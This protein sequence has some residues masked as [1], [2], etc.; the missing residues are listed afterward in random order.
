MAQLANQHYNIVRY[1]GTIIY[2][3]YIM[4]YMMYQNIFN[5]KRTQKTCNNMTKK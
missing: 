4:M 1:I 3:Y 2:I 5:S